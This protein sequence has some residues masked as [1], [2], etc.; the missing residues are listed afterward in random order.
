M[1]RPPTIATFIGRSTNHI[2]FH[3]YPHSY[4]QGMAIILQSTILNYELWKSLNI[5]AFLDRSWSN[6][7]FCFDF[8]S[9]TAIKCILKS[10]ETSLCHF[11]VCF[12]WLTDF[13]EISVQTS[14]CWDYDL[15]YNH[16]VVCSIYNQLPS[17]CSENLHVEP[18]GCK[19]KLKTVQ[20]YG[21]W[22]LQAV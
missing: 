22:K 2:W 7:K 21:N 19:R 16:I 12:F 6:Y 18:C 5:E 14:L 15:I 13:L 3:V 11:K 1:D 10:T 9:L 4:L 8:W 20:Y 17:C